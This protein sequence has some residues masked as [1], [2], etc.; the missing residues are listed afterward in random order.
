MISRCR[1]VEEPRIDVLKGEGLD[2]NTNYNFWRFADIQESNSHIVDETRAEFLFEDG[3]IKIKENALNKHRKS[4]SICNTVE[5]LNQ[6]PSLFI[7][8]LRR[9]AEAKGIKFEVQAKPEGGKSP[10]REKPKQMSKLSKY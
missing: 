8:Y 10:Q 4:I 1:N 9:L 5:R 6:H 7:N 3:E 2:L